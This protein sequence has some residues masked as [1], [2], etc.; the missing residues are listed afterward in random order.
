MGIQRETVMEMHNLLR[1]NPRCKTTDVLD[2]E[3]KSIIHLK[4]SVPFQISAKFELSISLPLLFL[5]PLSLNLMID[6]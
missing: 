5:F 6:F 2:T 3:E 4:Y 1:Y